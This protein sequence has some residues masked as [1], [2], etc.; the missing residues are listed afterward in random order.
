MEMY[1]YLLSLVPHLQKA[2]GDYGFK[3]PT[4]ALILGN[5]GYKGVVY[6]TLPGSSTPPT[7]S[8]YSLSEPPPCMEPA[9]RLRLSMQ[10]AQLDSS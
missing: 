9:A 7:H 5:S 8:D 6:P 10:I 1:R 2:T 3:L 4:P